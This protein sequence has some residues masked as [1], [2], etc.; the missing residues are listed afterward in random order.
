LEIL[1]RKMP[2]K[3]SPVKGSFYIERMYWFTA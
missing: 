3:S 2:K 1:R